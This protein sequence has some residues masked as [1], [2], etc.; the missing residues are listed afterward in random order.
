MSLESLK[1]LFER[2]FGVPVLQANPLQGELGGSGRRIIRLAGEGHSAVG[3]LY[4]VREENIAFLEFSR[5]F[6]LRGLPVPE[7]YEEDLAQGAYLE[8]DL[9]DTTLFDFLSKGRSGED[10]PG[11]V[12]AAYK[13]VVEILPRFQIEAG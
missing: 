11:D 12:V 13:K 4:G 1:K 7:I 5:H 3:I 9:G 8:E 2:H 6:R 10:I